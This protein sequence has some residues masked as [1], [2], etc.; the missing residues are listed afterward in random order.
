M[1]VGVLILRSK[2]ESLFETFVNIARLVQLNRRARPL[3]DRL[4]ATRLHASISAAYIWEGR[5]SFGRA[6]AP[7]LR[8]PTGI[9]GRRVDDGSLA[10]SVRNP[11]D[12]RRAHS[13]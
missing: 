7:W 13:R 3:T 10:H 9:D 6:D 12:N 2:L 5:S 11:L 1:Q 8:R 4:T